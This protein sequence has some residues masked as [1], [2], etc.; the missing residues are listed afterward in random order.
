MNM[1]QLRKYKY[2]IVIGIVLC[3]LIL[4]VFYIKNIIHNREKLETFNVDVLEYHDPDVNSSPKD[5]KL[6]LSL[7]KINDQQQKDSV[8]DQHVDVSQ[9][10]K[11]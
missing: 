2:L 1:T 4:V 8:F 7:T 11:A 6:Q 3:I 9:L 10:P 5:K